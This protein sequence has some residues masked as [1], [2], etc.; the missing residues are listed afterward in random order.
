L[1]TTASAPGAGSLA[2]EKPAV[3]THLVALLGKLETPTDGVEDYCHWLGRAFRKTGWELECLQFPWEHGWWTAF[4]WLWRHSRNWQGRW[5]FVQYTA[6]MWSAHGFPFALPIIL[7][8]LKF[9]RCNVGVIFHDVYA[10]PGSRWINRVRVALQQRIML[11]AYWLADRSVLPVPLDS[12][13]WLPD[14]APKASFVPVGANIP[15]LDDLAGDGFVPTTSL[16]PKVAVFGVSTWPSAK[17]QEVEAITWVLQ[18]VCSELGELHLLVIGRGAKEAEASLRSGL[19]GSRVI[20]TVDGLLPSREVS[21]R[22]SCCH[23]LLFVRGPLS[24]RRGSGLA[25]IACGL[26]IVA[27][28]GRETGFPLTQAGAVFVAQDDVLALADGLTR[29]LRDGNLRHSLCVRNHTVFR[30]WFAWDK[31]AERVSKVFDGTNGTGRQCV[32]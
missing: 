16:V 21:T 29:I 20:L 6:L 18:R 15:S 10:I 4:R 11:C 32:S 25:G 17:R 27:Y 5:V 31:I 2:G 3:G 1:L 23:A 26:P 24:T 12:V 19:S 9:R 22:L 7:G 28:A 30:E 13:P 8:I 14:P